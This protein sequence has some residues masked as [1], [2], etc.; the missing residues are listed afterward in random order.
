MRC[1]PRGEG[2]HSTR[3]EGGGMKTFGYGSNMCRAWFGLDVERFEYDCVAYL[4]GHSLTFDKQ[5]MDGT[6]KGNI[7]PR[8]R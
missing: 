8:R 3:S 7:V 4:S 6:G 2:R 5:S 1:L